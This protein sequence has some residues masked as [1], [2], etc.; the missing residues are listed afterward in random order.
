MPE[1]KTTS[2]YDLEKHVSVF[3]A[4]SIE[5]GTAEHWQK[6]F[7]KDIS[8]SD[9]LLILNPR[10][11]SWDEEITQSKHDPK[12]REQ[13]EWELK[14]QEDAD[15]IVM[16]F[17]PSTKSQVTMLELG[18]FSNTYKMVV[19]CSDGF[20]RKGNVDIVCE[21]W[22]IRHADSWEEFI[23]LSETMIAFAKRC[24]QEEICPD[25]GTVMVGAIM[26]FNGPE[27]K[28]SFNCKN[29]YYDQVFSEEVEPQRQE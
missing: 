14:A 24:R 28:M 1:V 8:N 7:I 9:D 22:N 20:C 19:Y 23:Q 26:P 18:L 13:V 12:F 15:V 4:G 25:C 27:L 29:C 17:D 11:D 6:R 21:R 5:M 16:Y 2:P 10:R 3:L